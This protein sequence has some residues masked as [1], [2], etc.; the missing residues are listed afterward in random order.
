MF[1]KTR[2]ILTILVSNS[3]ELKS[4]GFYKYILDGKPVKFSLSQTNGEPL[5]LQVF[6]PN[7]DEIRSVTTLI[8]KFCSDEPSSLKNLNVLVDDPGLSDQ[9]KKGYKDIR[10]KVN[11]YLDSKNSILIGKN[12][13][14]DSQPM[15]N[16]RDIFDIFINGKIF[17][18]K[19]EVKRKIYND[20]ESDNIYFGLLSTEMNSILINLCAAFSALAELSKKEL[21]L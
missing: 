5:I 14:E 18:D 12:G 7:S 6:G 9:W 10:E 16:R 1:D 17:H 19:D 21:G 3:N 11:Y 4:Y 20:W 2:E 13:E 15:P 8:R